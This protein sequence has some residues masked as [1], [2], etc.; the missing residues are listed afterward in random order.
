MQVET[1]A[2][3]IDARLLTN[4][5]DESVR[6]TRV[7]ASDRMSDLL[8]EVD[9]HTLLVTNLSHAIL[10]RP[11]E[12]MDIAAICFLSGVVPPPELVD[13]AKR[14]QAVVMVSPHGM[15]ETCG[16]LYQLMNGQP[17]E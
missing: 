4:G 3:G 16:R 8:N 13:A 5:V 1:I 17:G 7:Y 15:Y 6:I 12:L 9:D 10:A 11:I 2:E 14:Q